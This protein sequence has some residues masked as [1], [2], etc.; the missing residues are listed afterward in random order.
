MLIDGEKWACE[1]CVRGHRVT[2][3]KHNGTY[4]SI[5][6]LSFSKFSQTHIECYRSTI[7]P[8]RQKGSPL[9]DLLCMQ[10]HPMPSSRGAHQT[11]T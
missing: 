3:C 1:A 9:F 4:S 6:S 10:L 7:D 8:H 5:L 11:Q 2:T